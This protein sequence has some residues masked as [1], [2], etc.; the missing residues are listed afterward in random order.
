MA[1]F[2]VLGELD[3]PLEEVE[4]FSII[5][6]SPAYFWLTVFGLV[7]ISFASR[8]NQLKGL[9]GGCIGVLLSLIGYSTVFA[10]ERHTFG[11]YYLWD[12]VQLVPLVIGLFAI[13]EII[14][15]S[16]KGGSISQVSRFV[17]LEKS[18]VRKQVKQG[19]KDVFFRPLIVL[20]SSAIGAAI[21]A[22]PGVGG[23]VANFLSYTV[24]M[25][26]STRP[27]EYG[28]G[29]IE[30][31]VAS[32]T[33]NDAKDGPAIMT[34]V[35]FGV[36]GSPDTAV[37]I[38]ALILHGL[39]PGPLLLRDDMP[40]VMML[41]L[42]LLFA[43]VF[44]F[45][46]GLATAGLLARITAINVHALA[47]IVLLLCVAG[48]FALRQNVW[49]VLFAVLVGLIG[50]LLKRYH[51][52]VIT[53]L[54]GYMLGE[55]AERFFYTSLSVGGGSYAVFVRNPVSIVLIILIL[56][57]M[58]LPFVK[59][60]Q[61]NR[62]IKQNEAGKPE[63]SGAAVSLTDSSGETK[64][65]KPWKSGEFIFTAAAAVFVFLI[66]FT[67]F[68]FSEKVRQIPVLVSSAALILLLG[69]LVGHFYPA[70]MKRVDVGFFEEMQCVK[71]AP[72]AQ[73]ADYANAPRVIMWTVGLFRAIFLFLIG[74]KVS[75][76]LF[77]LLYLWIEG[78]LKLRKALIGAAVGITA[79]QNY[80]LKEAYGFPFK[81]T[82]IPL[83]NETG[84]II[85]SLGLALSNLS[86]H[87]TNKKRVV[88]GLWAKPTLGILLYIIIVLV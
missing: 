13:S 3:H 35:A 7:T 1:N 79:Q 51:F 2:H 10:V 75:I 74:L 88:I 18:I 49:D 24:A 82:A 64:G 5:F 29:S 44:T 16:S 45:N 53:I 30:G 6:K 37:L 33:A 71:E 43:K 42:G 59:S 40:I 19:I 26:N 80:F 20:R 86:R 39:T 14:M 68:E 31:L 47:L 55:M 12:G 11:S 25:H 65:A 9:A 61:Q 67:S 54:I 15:Y 22:I 23:T 17:S 8:G 36:P 46:F 62:K 21:A 50:Y 84:K 78:K 4:W 34:T 72:E 41:I 60:W 58:I 77:L 56:S 69:L 76:P 52:S 66:L 87:A 57:M 73:K 28:K 70:L 81:S 85:G 83:K 32:E 48:A 38:A 27:E 63:H